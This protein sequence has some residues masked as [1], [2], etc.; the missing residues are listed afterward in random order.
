M[1]MQ[2]AMHVTAALSSSC[3]CLCVRRWTSPLNRSLFFSLSL[4]L[5]ISPFPLFLSR[6]HFSVLAPSALL[7]ITLL[8]DTE[9]CYIIIQKRLR[10]YE[11]H[12]M[13]SWPIAPPPPPPPP[14]Y[15]VAMNQWIHAQD[16]L[17][18]QCNPRRE[19]GSLNFGKWSAP[20]WRLSWRG[21]VELRW[22]QVVPRLRSNCE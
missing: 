18:D 12:A 17:R 3:L 9:L 21:K 15:A 20:S 4:S 5:S 22:A 6:A 2:C 8:H 11:I 10:S 13:P 14:S 16:T 1:H 7:S 19:R